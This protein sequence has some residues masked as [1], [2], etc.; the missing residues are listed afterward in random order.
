MR[1]S[2]TAIVLQWAKHWIGVDLVAG[3]SQE[4][5]GIVAA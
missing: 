4:T 5:G 3:A 1:K 2:R